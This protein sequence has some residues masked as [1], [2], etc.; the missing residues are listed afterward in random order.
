MGVR[1]CGG[2]RCTVWRLVHG[3][4]ARLHIVRFICALIVVQY[5][6]TLLILSQTPALVAWNVF[7]VAFSLLLFRLSHQAYRTHRIGFGGM[8]RRAGG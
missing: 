6:S 5:V 7:V 4:L 2:L 8:R 3:P 1:A